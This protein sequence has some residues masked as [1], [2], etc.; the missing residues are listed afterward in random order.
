MNFTARQGHFIAAADTGS[1]TLASKRAGISQSAIST[2]ISHTERELDLQL[3]LRHH[4]QE[5][6]L[7]PAGRTL[8][9]ERRARMVRR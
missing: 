4:A 5:L 3:F 1:I 6:S 7:T 8:L 9:R 2:A